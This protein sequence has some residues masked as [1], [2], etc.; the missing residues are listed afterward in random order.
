VRI[1][2]EDAPGRRKWQAGLH[3]EARFIMN[4]E[5]YHLLIVS[6]ELARKRSAEIFLEE[7]LNYW[8]VLRAIVEDESA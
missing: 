1:L 7:R 4:R 3:Y 2:R 8:F 5:I 6:R